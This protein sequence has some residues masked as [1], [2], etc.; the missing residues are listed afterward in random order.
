[1]EEGVSNWYKLHYYTVESLFSVC[2]RIPEK[3]VYTHPIC[4]INIDEIMEN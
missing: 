2:V 1:M 4:S 3:A